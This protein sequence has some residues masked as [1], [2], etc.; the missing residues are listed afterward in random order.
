MT[1]AASPSAA[2]NGSVATQRTSPTSGNAGE[3]RGPERWTAETEEILAKAF[4]LVAYQS[5]GE[6]TAGIDSDWAAADEE[7][8]TWVRAAIRPVLAALADAGLLLP[9]GGEVREEFGDRVVYTY[10]GD[11]ISDGVERCDPAELVCR[12]ETHQQHNRRRTVYTG[13]WQEV[14]HDHV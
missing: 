5:E 11:V 13:P 12:H 4:M 14:D 1:A 9:P 7:N 10:H 3:G 2:A 6:D 8:R